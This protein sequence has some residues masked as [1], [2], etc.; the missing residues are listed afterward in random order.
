MSRDVHNTDKLAALKERLTHDGGVTII[1]PTHNWL[2]SNGH[3]TRAAWRRFLQDLH[4]DGFIEF[5][6]LTTSG[7][8]PPRWSVRQIA[9]LPS[10]WTS[11]RTRALWAGYNDAHPVRDHNEP[12]KAK[13]APQQLTL[14]EPDATPPATQVVTPSTVESTDPN[15]D[16]FALVRL[17]ARM[18]ENGWMISEFEIAPPVMMLKV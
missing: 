11:R 8:T 4:E 9:P 5:E 17:V 14:P 3:R 12:R 16:Y 13:K 6:S 10:T 7:Q 15:A 18:R 2:R 1:T